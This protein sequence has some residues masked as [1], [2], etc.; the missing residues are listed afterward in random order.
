MQDKILY[1]VHPSGNA[2]TL[3]N[4]FRGIRSPVM[5]HLIKAYQSDEEL[6]NKHSWVLHGINFLPMPIHESPIM[7][8]LYHRPWTNR[9]V[10]S[11]KNISLMLDII[12]LYTEIMPGTAQARDEMEKKTTEM[13][14]AT[15]EQIERIKDPMEFVHLLEEATI[16]RINLLEE[17]MRNMFFPQVPLEACMTPREFP[18]LPAE[19][20]PK[21]MQ[22]LAHYFEI[23]QQ[24]RHIRLEKA[25]P[26][27]APP[28][29]FR[30]YFNIEAM[31]ERVPTYRGFLDEETAREYL[32]FML[33]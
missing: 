22:L 1:D 3:R 6:R 32:N 20:A 18:A 7:C 16:R 4:K 5:P 29:E 2:I 30:H 33:E 10:D 14:R 25:L 19:S 26:D 31:K 11:V 27:H 28:R 23:K 15:C 13:E 12:N 21:W 9:W 17:C 24:V 8:L